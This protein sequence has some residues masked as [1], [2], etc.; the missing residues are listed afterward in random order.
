MHL[1]LREGQT[2]L[3]WWCMGSLP[4]C[5]IRHQS[6]QPLRHDPVGSEASSGPI[7]AM[8]STAMLPC[9]SRIISNDPRGKHRQ[10]D[11]YLGPIR[12]R[13]KRRTTYLHDCAEVGKVTPVH[14]MRRQSL[15]CFPPTG[16]GTCPNVYHRDEKHS[17]MTVHE[18]SKHLSS[19]QP[20]SINQG[21]HIVPLLWIL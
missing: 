3:G 4:C 15:G 18:T 12:Q 9:V 10:Q 11:I 6:T 2:G 17:M 19:F 21:M 1:K 5:R 7:I 13:P 20:G 14:L 16:Q 8:L